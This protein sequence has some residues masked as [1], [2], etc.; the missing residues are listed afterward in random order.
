[1]KQPNNYAAWF[2][3]RNIIVLIGVVTSIVLVFYVKETYFIR[4][5]VL[6]RIFEIPGE[7]P[8]KEAKTSIWE[9]FGFG[10]KYEKNIWDLWMDHH[11]HLSS[12]GDIYDKCG[13]ILPSRWTKLFPLQVVLSILAV[14]EYR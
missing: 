14:T 3:R 4:A 13:K 7:F 1:M 12:I 11:P 6:K 8:V 9:Y 2:S 10:E 5:G